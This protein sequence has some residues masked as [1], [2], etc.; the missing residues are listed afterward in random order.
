MEF[1]NRAQVLFEN[2]WALTILFFCILHL[3][4]SSFGIPGG[5]TVLNISAGWVFGFALGCAVVYPITLLGGALVYFVGRRFSHK[6]VAARYQ[7]M[8]ERITQRM[9][10]GDFLFFVS[11]RLSPFPP[12][13]LLN[14]LCGWLRVPF[15]LFLMSTTAGVFFDVILLTSIG[16]AAR[17]GAAYEQG[18]M[19]P[20][21][22]LLLGLLWGLRSFLFKERD[23]MTLLR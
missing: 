23:Q 9:G 13:G 2:Y 5:C 15:P 19:L 10:R 14:L 22:V 20:I 21:F 18:W 1:V 11:L 6:P 16:A 7:N 12:Y 4:A 17:A 3:L 8:V